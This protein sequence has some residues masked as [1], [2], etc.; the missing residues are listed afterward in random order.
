MSELVSIILPVYNGEQY[1]RESIDSVIAQTYQNWELIIIDDCS[2][3]AS[4]SIAASY[5]ERDSRIR[6]YR[7][8]HNLK[9]PR[10][11]NR[12]FSLAKG[13]YLTW[14]SDD[15]LYLPNAVEVMIGVLKAEHTDFVFA[16]CDIINEV[17]EVVDICKAPKDFKR[18]IIGGNYIGA[19]FLYTG[20]VYNQI[21]DYRPE[22]F[23]VE[24][25]DY[26]LRIFAKFEVSNIEEVLYQYR[27][28]DASLTNTE[29]KD[30]INRACESVIL[31][32]LP[33][34]GKLSVV[35]KA[36]LYMNLNHLRQ[37]RDSQEERD[38]YKNKAKFYGTYYK[39]FHKYPRKVIGKIK[40]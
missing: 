12:G 6:Y 22:K 40:R 21:G 39:V 27:R 19:C 17:G 34:F 29:K 32:N 18:A 23:L 38:Y 35:Q 11:L 36:Y 33:D 4:P 15:N 7:N 5:A 13:E 9:L 37:T 2:S 26:W 24:D 10:S 28:H 25:Y 20:K 16:T 30:K 14:T 3:D 8:E 1:L 31:E